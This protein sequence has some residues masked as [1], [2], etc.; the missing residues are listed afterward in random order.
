MMGVFLTCRL[1]L[2]FVPSYL[3][4]SKH[5]TDADVERPNV[6]YKIMSLRKRI[7]IV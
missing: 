3:G 6:A 1:R 5:H 7:R 4:R 2:P